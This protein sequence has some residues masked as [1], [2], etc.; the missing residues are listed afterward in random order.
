M[1]SK[2]LTLEVFYA[3]KSGQTVCRLDVEQGTTVEQA[4]VQ[5]A[6]LNH[7]PEIDLRQQTVGVYSRRVSLSHLVC[8]GDRIEIYRP[9]VICPKERRRLLA[10]NA[11]QPA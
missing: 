3:S 7:Y 10:A 9:L 4:I 1:A 2:L 8:D 6:I 11:K 5:S